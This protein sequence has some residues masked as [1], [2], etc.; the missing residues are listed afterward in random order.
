MASTGECGETVVAPATAGTPRLG[1]ARLWGWQGRLS[2]L[3]REGCEVP[4]AV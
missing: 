1:V 4:A 2:G 3:S